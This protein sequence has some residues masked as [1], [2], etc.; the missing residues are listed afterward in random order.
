MSK[1]RPLNP[2]LYLLIFLFC[3]LLPLREAAGGDGELNKALRI[4][5]FEL[6]RCRLAPGTVFQI[7]IHKD[8]LRQAKLAQDLGTPQF[9]DHIQGIH[10]AYEAAR[11]TWGMNFPRRSGKA[12]WKKS[13]QRGLP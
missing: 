9:I 10:I 2:F 12:T 13:R 4:N 5:P 11:F 6:V 3:F 7:R 8:L 1:A